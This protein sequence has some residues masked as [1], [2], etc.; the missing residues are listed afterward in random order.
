[1]IR[2]WFGPSLARRIVIA[3][4]LAFVL[5]DLALLA[6]GYREFKDDFARSTDLLQLGRSFNRQLKAITNKTE[7]IA[8]VRSS[9]ALVNEIRR[10]ADYPMRD[11]LWQLFDRQGHLLYASKGLDARVIPAIPDRVSPILIG[12]K[13]YRS[14]AADSALWK[15][16]FAEPRISDRTAVAW[17]STGTL[18]SLLLA[19]PL[20]LLPVWFGV[21]RGLRPLRRLKEHL[22]QRAPDDLSPLGIDMRYPEL[23][24]VT[25][26]FDGLLAKLRQKVERER[27]FVQ[28]AAHELRTPMAVISAQAHV[29]ARATNAEDKHQAEAA[30]DRAIARASHLTR[31]L[32]TLASLDHSDESAAPPID[33][34]ALI[35]QMLAQIANSAIARRIELSLDAP[36]R[37][38]LAIKQ[39]TLESIVQNLLDNALK[40]GR[41][42]GRI[43]VRLEARQ[44]WIEL[45]VADDGPGVA[46]ED[47]EHL[48][49]RFYRGKGHDAPGTGLGLA[50]CHEAVLALGG[51][52]K[53]K[54]GLDGRGA[55]FLVRLPHH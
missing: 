44:A 29:L 51:S 30:L 26:A 19:F 25:I 54:E 32:L 10:N 22:S 52:L 1:M 21:S 45:E 34:A 17:I 53:L 9:E 31:Q 37:L 13:D 27:A 49:E 14:L 46:P 41:E 18:P 50:I 28:D 40:Y 16:R 11:C 6:N 7:A 4:V 24:Q 5:V 39:P 48:F 12:G 20:I 55:G 15:L 35:Q 42:G 3:M 23:A 36:E 38:M 43:A 8:L 2:S 47:R 33:I